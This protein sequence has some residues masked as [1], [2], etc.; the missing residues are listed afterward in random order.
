[1]PSRLTV[2]GK[3]TAV[4]DGKTLSLPSGVNI[5]HKGNVYL[6]G[7]QSGNSVRAEDNGTY[8]NVSVGLGHWPQSVHG[9]LA[10]ANGR[11]NEVEAR[12]GKVLTAP[13]AM[14]D[15]YH[16]YADSW[17]VPQAESLLSA[18]SDREIERGI[19]TKPFYANNLDPQVYKRARGACTAA[20][21]KVKALL[22]A[23][24]LDVAVIGDAS[25]AKVFV[26]VRAPIAVG[27]VVVSRRGHEGDRD[28]HDKDHKGDDD[29]H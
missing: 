1:V 6:I 21:V 11:V 22:D 12:T 20:G 15:L 25:A 27:Q 8:I 29:R 16:E 5:L 10:N 7:D 24:T 23:C 17:R 2:D 18:C 13:F 4:E 28:D 14:E 9:I 3:S 26:G 19:P